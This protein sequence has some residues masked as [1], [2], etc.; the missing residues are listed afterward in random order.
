MLLRYAAL[1]PWGTS[2]KDTLPVA[3]VDGSLSERFSN[4][5]VQGRIH[6]KTGSLGGVKTLSG[7]AVTDRGEPVAFSI[8]SNNSNLS[9]KRVTDAIDNIVGEVLHDGAGRNAAR[10]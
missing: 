2:F 3:G 9:V 5:E 10:K 6:A 7:Y 4:M 8:L 1:Q